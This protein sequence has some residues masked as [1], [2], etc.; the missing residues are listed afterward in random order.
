MVH[1][2]ESFHLSRVQ[3]LMLRRTALLL[4]KKLEE[5]LDVAR[6]MIVLIPCIA[7]K[8]TRWKAILLHKSLSSI[9]A[10]GDQGVVKWKA[11][12]KAHRFHT[13]I[14]NGAHRK[15]MAKS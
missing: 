11:S 10:F 4:H 9:Q 5:V 3:E 7:N 2:F 14:L 8:A 1:W 6:I 12:R 15:S 13:R